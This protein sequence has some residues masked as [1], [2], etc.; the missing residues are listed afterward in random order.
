M[1]KKKGR[2]TKRRKENRAGNVGGEVEATQEGGS[3]EV[4]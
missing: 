4:G 2:D 3:W 1:D